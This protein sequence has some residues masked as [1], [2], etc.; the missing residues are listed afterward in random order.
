MS[1]TSKVVLSVIVILL[2]ALGIWYAATFRQS[3][4]QAALNSAPSAP[5]APVAENGLNTSP[6]DTS[7]TAL[8][9]DMGSINS[10][11]QGLSSDSAAV[12]ESMQTP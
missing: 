6:S 11:M 7:N 9:Q 3:N 10:Q 1:T 4:N 8:V 2:I 5:S 12:N